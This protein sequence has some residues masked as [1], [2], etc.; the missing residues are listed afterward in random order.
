M[1]YE[2]VW[3]S[4]HEMRSRR[5]TV[6]PW[7]WRTSRVSPF[8]S[9]LRGN[10]SSLFPACRLRT[11]LHTFYSVTVKHLST[12]C[13]SNSHHAQPLDQVLVVFAT[14]GE[15]KF[16]LVGKCNVPYVVCKLSD[17]IVQ[18]WWNLVFEDVLFIYLFILE[19]HM[20]NFA[21]ILPVVA[22]LFHADRQ[23]WRS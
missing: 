20:S 16:R 12:E 5:M 3:R 14:N 22:E 15:H 18:L 2:P 19:L 17:I 10:V 4:I 11:G 6:Q 13:S 7:D 21:E 8:E 1:L 23:T 9:R